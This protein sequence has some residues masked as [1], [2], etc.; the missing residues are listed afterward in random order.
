MIVYLKNEIHVC[1]Y[2]LPFV[3]LIMLL[4]SFLDEGDIAA[5]IS[6]YSDN[7]CFNCKNTSIV[8]MNANLN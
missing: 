3:F 5:S 4:H 2:S 6:V 1:V 7:M 8:K